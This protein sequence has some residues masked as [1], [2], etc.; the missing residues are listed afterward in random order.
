[1]GFPKNRLR[2]LRS[3][4]AMR[5]LVRRTRVSVDDLVYPLFVR[6]GEGIEKPIKSMTGCYHFSPDT[7]GSQAVEVAAGVQQAGHH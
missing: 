6:E 1:M 5:R 2:R 7:I 4:P 3:S